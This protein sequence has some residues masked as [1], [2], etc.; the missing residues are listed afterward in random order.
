VSDI[1][2]G[3][4]ATVGGAIVGG[5]MAVRRMFGRDPET[6]EGHAR[7]LAEAEREIATLKTERAEDEVRMT[8]L[9]GRMQT[10]ETTL[11]GAI[12]K[13]TESTDRQWKAID[14]LTDTV[15]NLRGAVVEMDVETK[16]E[17][18]LR[19]HPPTDKE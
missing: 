15:D 3:I 12:G 4:A 2:H 6:P 13:L 18:A 11:A 5:V 14:R 1:D 17:R 7:R 10:T 19:R 8:K 16:I 9:E